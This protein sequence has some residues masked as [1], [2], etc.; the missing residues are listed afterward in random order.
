[1]FDY[2]PFSTRLSI[3]ERNSCRLITRLPAT[4]YIANKLNGVTS[5]K[6]AIL[7]ASRSEKSFLK[8]FMSTKN[9]SIVHH[10]L[11]CYAEWPWFCVQT[12][13][14][15]WHNIAIQC[16]VHKQITLVPIPQDNLKYHRHLCVS[17]YDHQNIRT[18][19]EMYG[20]TLQSGAF[21]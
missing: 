1:M 2:I 3:L 20:C 9:C 13:M 18:R 21:A 17:L 7:T 14:N 19:Q 12:A 6:S 10:A 4:R 11:D 15:Q 16:N 5:Q 8:K